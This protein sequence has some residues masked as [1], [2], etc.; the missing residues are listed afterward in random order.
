LNKNSIDNSKVISSNFGIKNNAMKNVELLFY[1]LKFL[2][3]K[4][5]LKTT[6]YYLLLHFNKKNAQ[7]P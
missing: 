4:K 7:K 1:G 6:P 3:E 2:M 5:D